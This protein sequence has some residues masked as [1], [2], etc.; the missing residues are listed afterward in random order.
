M[1]ER[2]LFLDD[3]PTRRRWAQREFGPGNHFEAVDNAEAAIACLAEKAYDLVY[4]DHDLD[5]E[6][7]ANPNGKN[8][9]SEVVRWILLNRPKIGKVIVHSMNTPQGNRM[10]NALRRRGYDATYRSWLTIVHDAARL[11]WLGRA[12]EGLT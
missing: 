8:T 2:I 3:C 12:T 11:P 9:G 10:A 1:S 7:W 4:L 5:G 6:A